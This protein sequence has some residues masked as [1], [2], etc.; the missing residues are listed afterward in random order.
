MSDQPTKRP[1]KKRE[2]TEKRKKY[3]Q[4]RSFKIKPDVP[5]VHNPEAK[6]SGK[7]LLPRGLRSAL[8]GQDISGLLWVLVDRELKGRLL[9]GESPLGEDT[10]MKMITELRRLEELKSSGKKSDE[11]QILDWVNS[12]V[13]HEDGEPIQTGW[14]RGVVF[15]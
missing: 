12:V 6:P 3:E 8:N 9:D 10:L 13:E 11:Q 4:S 1:Y 14:N 15:E 2:Y 5:T 7:K